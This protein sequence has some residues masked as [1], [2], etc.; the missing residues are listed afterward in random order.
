ML[1]VSVRTLALL[2]VGFGLKL[3]VTPLGRPLAVSVTLLLKPLSGVMAMDSVLLLAPWVTETLG[4][5]A[6][7]EKLATAFTVRAMVVE[8]V[9]VPEVPVMVTVTGP[10]AVAVLVAVSVTTLELVAGLVAKEAVTP[11]GRPLAA[12][13]TAPANPP[14]P[15]MVSVSVLV[16]PWARVTLGAVGESV[17]PVPVPE[18][19]TMA[20]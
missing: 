12:S 6:A 14:S 4:A 17:N 5:E 19:V 7:S 20:L 9:N 18:T 15:V 16:L 1:A 13:V 11:L 8:A 2:V 3:A 10:P